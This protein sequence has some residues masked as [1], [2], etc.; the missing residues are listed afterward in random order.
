MTR[1]QQHTAATGSRQR[2]ARHRTL[3]SWSYR[4][5]DGTARRAGEAAVGEAAVG[6]G[7]HTRSLRS[8]IRAVPYAG[9]ACSCWRRNSCT[10][11]TARAGMSCPP[12]CSRYVRAAP[13]GRIPLASAVPCLAIPTGVVPSAAPWQAQMRELLPSKS[14]RF[15][16]KVASGVPLS[17]NS[18]RNRPDNKQDAASKLG[19]GHE[20]SWTA[21]PI[22]A[23]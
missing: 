16:I 11:P 21:Q 20:A 15:A 5:T 23:P 8:A 9:A 12:P 22:V 4:R 1:R 7:R 18:G 10:R 14:E 17:P 2:P 6:S 3:T 19:R 13:P